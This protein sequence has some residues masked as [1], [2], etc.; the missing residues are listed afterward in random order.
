MELIVTFT[1][2]K[3]CSRDI[4]QIYSPKCGERK[5][6]KEKVIKKYFT[7]HFCFFF[8]SILGV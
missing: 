5:G 7:C 6:D 2:I 1:I 8:K 4:V 3:Y